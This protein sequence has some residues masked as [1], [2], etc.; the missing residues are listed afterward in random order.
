M[1]I[2]VA[3]FIG[4]RD[5]YYYYLLYY[6][7]EDE[8]VEEQ[9]PLHQTATILVLPANIFSKVLHHLSRP[10]VFQ[11]QQTLLGLS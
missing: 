11:E 7:Y 10:E 2:N 1:L 4:L 5:I 8:A 3:R 9:T 6:Y